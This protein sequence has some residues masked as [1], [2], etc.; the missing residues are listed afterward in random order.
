MK[1]LNF[2]IASMAAIFLSPTIALAASNS[3]LSHAELI[4]ADSR[5]LTAESACDDIGR[6]YVIG[7]TGIPIRLTN[8]N[9][10]GEMS[11]YF[12]TRTY[13]FILSYAD[14]EREQRSAYAHL[15][16]ASIHLQDSENLL[17]ASPPLTSKT[18]NQLYL[19]Y[20]LNEFW[21]LNTLGQ[22]DAETLRDATN[23]LMNNRALSGFQIS[24]F[25]KSDIPTLP[26]GQIFGSA[27]YETCLSGN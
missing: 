26:V 1:V 27:R 19:T 5:E 9:A 16:I 3:C 20:I 15:L 13:L 18:R 11:Y 12:L 7:V 4:E 10:L 25:V 21:R 22:R 6:A 17:L 23:R 8:E 24:C 2:A 14:S